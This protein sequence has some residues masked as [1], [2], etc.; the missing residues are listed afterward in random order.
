MLVTSLALHYSMDCCFLFLSLPL[1]Y[2]LRFVSLSNK[3]RYIYIY[4]SYIYIYIYICIIYIYIY[5]CI[6]YIIYI[7]R[8]SKKTV[9][10][11]FCQ[12]FVKFL[13]ILIIFGRQM[14]KWLELYAI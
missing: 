13:S 1:C 7:H 11:C 10:N 2:M 9:Q 8:V 12:N 14:R 3:R 5:I 4:S 6:T